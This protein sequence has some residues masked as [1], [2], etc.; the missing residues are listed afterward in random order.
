MIASEKMLL[1]DFSWCFINDVVDDIIEN[2][3]LLVAF[4][5]GAMQTTI[6]KK[7]SFDYII[8]IMYLQVFIA[9]E[10]KQYCKH[11]TARQNCYESDC[12]A[13]K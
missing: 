6:Y 12:I 2:I 1:V 7:S 11:F 10:K 13:L 8:L 5:S 9:L 3:Q 4:F